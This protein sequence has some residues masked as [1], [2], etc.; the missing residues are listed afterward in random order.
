MP[1]RR[2]GSSAA[3]KKILG[4]E[5]FLYEKV[6]C[7]R[8]I[9]LKYV[10]LERVTQPFGRLWG[11][12]EPQRGP[13]SLNGEQTMENG[14]VVNLPI[15][16]APSQNVSKGPVTTHSGSHKRSRKNI[17]KKNCRPLWPQLKSVFMTR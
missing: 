5:Q 9:L 14:T 13:L 8:D 15:G 16:V 17:Q 7:S 1:M 11:S 3:T 4:S 12:T 2:G 10:S 6:G